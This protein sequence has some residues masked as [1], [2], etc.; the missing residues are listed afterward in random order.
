MTAPSAVAPIALPRLKAP[1]FMAEATFGASAAAVM[2]RS[3]SGGTRGETSRSPEEDQHGRRDG[4]LHCH[5]GKEQQAGQRR[6]DD[7][8]ARSTRSSEPRLLPRG[9]GWRGKVRL[10]AARVARP[11]PAIAQKR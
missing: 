2:T 4:M 3:C 9:A 11:T 10:R 8:A 5:C 7:L 1:M 6:H